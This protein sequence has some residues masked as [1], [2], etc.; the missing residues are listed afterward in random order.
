[1]AEALDT[2]C[3]AIAA[4]VRNVPGIR[5]THGYPPDSVNAFPVVVVYPGSGTYNAGPVGTRMGLHDITI[6]LLIPAQQATLDRDFVTLVP[7]VDTIPAALLAEV[8]GDN[9][10][11]F[12]NTIDTFGRIEYT[13]LPSVQYAADPLRGYR[14]VIR[15]VKILT[16]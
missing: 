13:F 3:L 4:V 7:L 10:G 15:Q 5:Q 1:M 6:D 9:A 8:S 14:F 16:T 11:R 2:A 12:G